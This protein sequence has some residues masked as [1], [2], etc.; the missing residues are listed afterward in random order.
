MSRLS[1]RAMLKS[2]LAAVV[3][4]TA[5]GPRR[6]LAASR[7]PLERASQFPLRPKI[8]DRILAGHQ[9]ILDELRPTP[10]QLDRGLQLHYDSF[11]ADMQGNISVTYAGGLVGDRLAGD[12]RLKREKART[13][14]SA[15]DPQWIN[16]SRALYAIAGVHVA[17]EDVAHPGE[18]D[19]DSAL[20][21][22]ARSNY[23]YE[24]RPDMVRV[25]G[26]EDVEQ[27]RRAG[28]VA[29]IA[30]LAA[31]GCFA[32][33]EDPLA[34]LDL[35]YALGV[36]MSQLTYIQKNKLCCSWFQEDDTGLTDLGRQ[37]I[38]RMNEIG[39]MVDVAHCGPR[40]AMEAVEASAE[41]VIISHTGC[42]AVFD[43]S[44]NETYINAVLAQPYARGVARPRKTSPRNAADE[45]MKAAAGKGG[46]VGLFVIHYMLERSQ[47]S[48]AGWYKHVE[49]AIQVAGIDHVAVGSDFGF[50]PGWKPSALD[51]AN[52]PY[53]TV[54][55]VCRGLTDEQVR[56]IIGG[57]FLRYAKQSL[58]KRPWGELM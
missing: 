30:H 22:L 43:D 33:A 21:L 52:W 4:G 58:D 10:A 37:A 28:T 49:H 36:R 31:A 29:V 44:S 9:A 26:W 5:V 6:S 7:S 25:S 32:E 13:F 3:A 45:L 46:L 53:W 16:E 11:V 18:N 35:F 8:R 40:S 14:E 41:P 51:W 1:R 27:A 20:R 48:F 38:R 55:L 42:K 17:S 47:P 23:V 2:S 54:G 24:R 19:C 34:N 39:V 56:K 50:L 12:R 15:Y 57:N